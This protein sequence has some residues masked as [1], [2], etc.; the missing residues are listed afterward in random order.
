MARGEWLAAAL[1]RQGEAIF[2]CGTMNAEIADGLCERV[3]EQTEKSQ[4][5][6]LLP[7]PLAA[8]GQR[9]QDSGC[10]WDK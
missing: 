4:M 8:T 2:Q 7:W 1:A 10:V 3:F 6:S 9:E 5:Y